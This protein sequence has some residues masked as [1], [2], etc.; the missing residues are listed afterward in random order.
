MTD[1]CSTCESAVADY[2]THDD[3]IPVWEDEEE[4]GNG[5]GP[6]YVGCENC[7]RFVEVEDL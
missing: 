6:D 4:Y 1:G 7:G 5:E 2:A 3:L